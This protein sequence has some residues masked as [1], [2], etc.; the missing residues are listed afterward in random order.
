MKASVVRSFVGR[1][2]EP[3]LVG[4]LITSRRRRGRRVSRSARSVCVCSSGRCLFCRDVEVISS[5]IQL[6]HHHLSSSPPRSPFIKVFLVRTTTTTGRQ[7]WVVTYQ[8]SGL[9]CYG[10]FRY[11]ACC[12][13][14]YN[15]LALM[16]ELE[17]VIRF[18][19]KGWSFIFN[20]PKFSRVYSP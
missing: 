6:P 18:S 17:M 11:R 10:A 15:A 2:C 3:A 8:N 12:S 1:Q 20:Y 14:V 13:C 5:C 4:W 9:H 16:S 19:L 7:A